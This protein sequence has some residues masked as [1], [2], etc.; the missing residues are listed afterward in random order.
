MTKCGFNALG[1]LFFSSAGPNKF[2]LHLIC[3]NLQVLIFAA[4]YLLRS[5]NQNAIRHFGMKL[6][7]DFAEMKNKT[8]YERRLK[9]TEI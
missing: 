2:T 3:L 8:K 7:I 5:E 1:F 4:L 9:H 6:S